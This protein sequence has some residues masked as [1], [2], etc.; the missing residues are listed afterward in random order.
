MGTL[1][2]MPCRN[3]HMTD[4]SSPNL[5]VFCNNSTASANT[6]HGDCLIIVSVSLCS[7]LEKAVVLRVKWS[8][9]D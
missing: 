3:V 8:A 1:F 5:S 7:A 4:F 9:V 2:N 6:F